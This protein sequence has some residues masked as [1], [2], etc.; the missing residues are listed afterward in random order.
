MTNQKTG[1]CWVY[2]DDVNTDVIFPGKYTYNLPP[3]EFAKH[4][5][6][7]LDPDFA[8]GVKAGDVIVG[9]KN[10]GC[11]SSREQAAVCIKMSG[12]TVIVA[13]SF[14]RIFFRNCVNNG[15]LPLVCPEAVDHIQKGDVVEV[16]L[17]R[18]LI[19]VKTGD[20]RLETGNGLPSSIVNHQF[21][22]P[23]LSPSVMDIINAGGLIPML[24][25][26]LGTE[27]LPMPE[28]KFAGEG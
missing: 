20:E 17:A 9:G 19:T 6:E 22:F 10:F 12:V 5:L 3:S 23:P 11:G 13:R 24:R 4:A 27:H 26:K 28:V 16:D 18:N 7:D 2:G 14:A 21:P 15:V 1:A 8:K 25:H